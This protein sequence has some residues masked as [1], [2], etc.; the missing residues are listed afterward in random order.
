MTNEFWPLTEVYPP[1]IKPVHDGDYLTHPHPGA[2]FPSLMR[3]R[4]GTGWHFG[5]G[6]LTE[7][8]SRYW[9][10]LAFDP[11]SVARTRGDHRISESRRR[12]DVPGTFIPD[13][14]QSK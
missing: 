8:Q 2:L 7:Y 9:Q 3:W 13:G 14:G 10:G 12:V 5:N 4:N 6:A 11:A 1:E